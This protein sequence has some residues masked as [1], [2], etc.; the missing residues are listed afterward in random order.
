M[1]PKIKNNM[2]WGFVSGRIS[3]LEGKLLPREFFLNLIAQDH[4]D[5]LL[6]H[7]QETF[8]REYLSPGT[9]WEDFTDLCDRCFHE[10]ALS[11]KGDCPSSL[12]A[13]LFLLPGNYLN[14]KGALTGSSDFPFHPGLLSL[15]KLL[16]IG[17]G[18]YVDLPSS[19]QQS[20]TYT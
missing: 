1:V 17:Q 6:Q 12:P 9:V 13:D 11:I 20:E 10:M 3:V 15:E 4:L 8:L 14:L 16:G 19:L 2:R 18:D 5:D 7:L